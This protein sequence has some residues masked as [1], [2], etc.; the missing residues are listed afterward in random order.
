[1]NLNTP[2]IPTLETDKIAHWNLTIEFQAQALGISHHLND[3]NYQPDHFQDRSV[4]A[5]TGAILSSLPHNIASAIITHGT[6]IN[7]ASLI[8]KVH[9]HVTTRS[10][11]DHQSL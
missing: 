3:I 6:S 8:R 9:D 2:T 5:V 1:M 4:A 11:A 10:A 7:H